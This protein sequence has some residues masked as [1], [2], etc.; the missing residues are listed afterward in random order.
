MELVKSTQLLEE[1]RKNFV[2]RCAFPNC[3]SKIIPSSSLPE[4]VIL[5]KNSP[6]MLRL[7]KNDPNSPNQERNFYKVDDVWKF[8]NIGVS[9]KIPEDKGDV[10]VDDKVIKVQRLLVCSDCDKGPIGFAGIVHGDGDE[11]DNLVYFLG[12]DSVLYELLP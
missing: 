12:S 1:D 9:R 11:V 5:V 8:D 10:I 2:A 7:V 4:S 6:T 3:R